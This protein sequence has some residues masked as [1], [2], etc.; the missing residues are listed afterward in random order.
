[1]WHQKTTDFN[2]RRRILIFDGGKKLTGLQKMENFKSNR[3]KIF[4]R[5]FVIAFSNDDG[6]FL[7]AYT[8][9]KPTHSV[10]SSRATATPLELVKRR[11]FNII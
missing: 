2:K 7:S 11:K 5:I 8:L 6:F 3:T 4:T 10:E 1:M 9:R